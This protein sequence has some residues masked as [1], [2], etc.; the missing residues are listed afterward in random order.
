MKLSKNINATSENSAYI[1]YNIS[2]YKPLIDNTITEILNKFVSII[3]E[4][5][6]FISDKISLKNRIYH[7]FI[8]ERGIETLTHVFFIIFYYTK[9]L[10]LTYYH[11]QKAFY[12]Y[13]E[14]IEQIS[15]DNVTFLQLTSRDAITFVYKKTIFDINNEYKKN[16]VDPSI[17]EKY[18]LTTIEIYSHIYKIL[19]QYFINNFDFNYDKRGDYVNNCCN[20]I[21]NVS[22]QLNKNKIKRG[23][24][25]CI[26]LFISILTNN[27]IEINIL[28]E[29]LSEFIL[30]IS[31]KKKYDDKLIKT[32]IY[33]LN[34]SDIILN[35]E[36]NNIIQLVFQD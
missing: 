33:D 15:D 10:E 16:M 23:L 1:L 7:K 6:Q 8:M 32:R 17:D 28:M 30:K 13:V 9:N 34:I 14:F 12:F 22:E 19:I 18:I 31:S 5:I 4:Y 29:L 3:V 35:N 2:N 21:N 25:D 26:Y 27:Q 36:T 20:F 11:S 24:V